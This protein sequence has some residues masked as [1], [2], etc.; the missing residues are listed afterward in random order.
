[1]IDTLHCPD[2]D[3]TI[4]VIKI[5]DEGHATIIKIK[6]ELESTK[7][8][9]ANLNDKLVKSEDAQKALLWTNNKLYLDFNNHERQLQK[10]VA[11]LKKELD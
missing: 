10:E 2:F 6:E 5:M 9:Q 11:K 1:M 3:S 8:A 7:K 4:V